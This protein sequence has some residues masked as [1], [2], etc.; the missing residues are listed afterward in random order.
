V[1]QI[2][3]FCLPFVLV[4]SI[5]R[6]AIEAK[7]GWSTITL[8]SMVEGIGTVLAA[9]GGALLGGLVAISIAVVALKFAASLVQ[10]TVAIRLLGGKGWQVLAPLF[11][12]YLAGLAALAIAYASRD[13]LTL[14]FL[15][16]TLLNNSLT[17]VVY[18][19]IFLSVVPILC[20]PG[21]HEVRMMVGDGYKQALAKK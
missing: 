7:G 21:W 12:S 13:Y 2:L 19:G 20:R 16:S 11:A 3:S 4:A 17:I 15:D 14:Q 1:V 9:L 8:L 5:G 6:A 10:T 18:L